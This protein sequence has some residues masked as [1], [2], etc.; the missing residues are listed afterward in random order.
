MGERQ[1]DMDRV[2]FGCNL[3]LLEGGKWE[4]WKGNSGTFC[5]GS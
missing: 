1:E 5:E 4:F 2:N 3:R